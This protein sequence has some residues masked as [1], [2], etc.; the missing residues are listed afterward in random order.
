MTSMQKP[1]QQIRITKPNDLHLH[2]RQGDALKSV[3]HD[4]ARQFAQAIIMPNLPTPVTQVKQAKTYRQEIL[5]TLAVNEITSGN[6]VDNNFQPLMTLY[7][8]DNTSA[9]TIIEAKESGI[10]HALKLYP[11]GATTNSD[12]GVTDI[13][14][15]YP[16]L[17]AMQ[18]AGIPL[19][20]HGEVTD[21]NID[22]FDREKCFIDSVLAPLIKDFPTLKIV[23]EH[24]TTKNAVD[25]VSHAPD[26]IVAT[27]TAH[28][29]LINR[30]AIFTG[31]IRP[32]HY[33]LPV[34]KR[35][36]H[37]QALVAA[38]TSG[39]PKFFLGTDSAPHSKNAKESACGCAGMYTAHNAIELYAEVFDHADALDRLE[40]FSSTFGTEFYGLSKNN[41]TLVLQKEDWSVPK[42]LPYGDEVIIPFRAG[43]VCQWKVV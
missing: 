22:I 37:R 20:V 14:N 31:G 21:P 30:N 29:L 6:P 33:C 10:I 39:N 18:D 9:E 38:A 15:T 25:F 23:M 16:A 12:A 43:E 1:K 32:H 34:L 8:T 27:I 17:Q 35:E 26:H 19:L 41:D 28:H 2:V 40:D 36:E 24:I 13:N 11:A 3:I 5:D 42:E 4:T 7:L